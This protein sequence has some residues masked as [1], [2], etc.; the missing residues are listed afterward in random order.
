VAEA[1]SR[2][3]LTLP[4]FPAMTEADVRRVVGA[5]TRATA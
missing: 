5:L 3:I 2:Q 4:M 1:A